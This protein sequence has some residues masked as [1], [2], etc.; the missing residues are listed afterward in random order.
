[1]AVAF[2]Q[3]KAAN[4]GLDTVVTITFDSNVTAG[5]VIAGHVGWSST[6]AT[7]SSIADGLGN[8]YT[9]L[10]NPTTGAFTRAAQ[11]YAENISGGSCT[12]TV[13]FSGL[14]LAVMVAHEISGVATS[15][16]LDKNA[17]NAQ[18]NPGTGTDA[19]TSTSV[20][21]TTNGQYIFGAVSELNEMGTFTQGTGFTS[22]VDQAGYSS[23]DQVQ[24]SAG[25]IAATFTADAGF[26]VPNTGIMTFKAAGGGSGTFPGYIGPQGWF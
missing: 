23:E 5:N 4:N 7:I 16:A 12:I 8:T 24:T 18:T 22:R 2:V 1:M 19:V 14:V 15:S 25:A 26:L 9:P 11:F 20:T 6:T 21:T 17:M 3:S 13:T 10:N